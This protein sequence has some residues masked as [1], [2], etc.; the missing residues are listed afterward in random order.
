MIYLLCLLLLIVL[1][2]LFTLCKIAHVHVYMC[3]CMTWYRR[4]FKYPN[5]HLPRKIYW[6]ILCLMWAPTSKKVTFLKM[7]FTCLQF[8]SQ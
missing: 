8:N 5:L 6:Y 4:L 2:I 7:K 3:I 1:T